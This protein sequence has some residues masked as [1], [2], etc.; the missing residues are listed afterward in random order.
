MA[1]ELDI[2]DILG[3][4]CLAS[5]GRA[6]ATLSCLWMG[7]A[8]GSVAVLAAEAL[9]EASSG[10]TPEFDQLAIE[11]LVLVAWGPLLIFASTLLPL[12][13]PLVVLVYFRFA[14]GEGGSVR[15]WVIYAAITGLLVL[16]SLRFWR[17]LSLLESAVGAFFWLGFAGALG[18]LAYLILLWHRR[19]SNEHLMGVAAENEDRRRAFAEAD[20]TGWGNRVPPFGEARPWVAPPDPTAPHPKVPRP[21]HPPGKGENPTPEER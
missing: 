16:L 17:E 14:R 13:F 18:W 21:R 5:I 20:G 19:R 3:A 10:K 11:V 7:A 2:E 8:T 6:L 15:A 9:L 12:F 4:G 1:I